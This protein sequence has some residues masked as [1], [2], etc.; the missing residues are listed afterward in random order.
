[1]L[2]EFYDDGAYPF[3]PMTL[4]S[5]GA[6]YGVTEYGGANNGGTV[7]RIDPTGT[8]TSLYSFDY[9]HGGAPNQPLVLARDGALYGISQFGIP[10]SGVFRVDPSGTVDSFPVLPQ[11][12]WP[13]SPLVQGS[14]C[15]LYGVAATAPWDTAV[16][17]V[18]EPG[19]LCQ[20]V[21]FGSLPDGIVSDAPFT[22]SATAS[23]GLSVSFRAIGS[24]SVS[25][26]QVTL[27]GVGACTLTALQPGDARYLPATEVSQQFDVAFSFSGFL[28]PVENS[29][30]LN[31]VTGGQV[32]PIRFDLGVDAGRGV[33][34]EDSPTVQKIHCGTLAPLGTPER[35]HR[36]T[37]RAL[38][39]RRG[40][41]GYTYLWKTEKHWAG[42]CRQLTLE[43]DDGTEHSANFKFRSGHHF[44][45]ARHP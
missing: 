33:L 21:E 43:L 41:G 9:T 39:H 12:L 15:A 25:G 8:F 23:S 19:H 22:V 32:V 11:T 31:R 27:S 30:A 13:V 37:R 16:Y 34:A 1:M 5:D 4:G 2:H 38:V 3:A 29:P 14:D 42:S 44:Q 26:D 36:G 7:F 40:T 20:R 18:F 6:M 35:A 10:G 24:C 45:H 17:R 28:S